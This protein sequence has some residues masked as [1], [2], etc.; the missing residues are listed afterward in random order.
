MLRTAFSSIRK[1]GHHLPVFWTSV[2]W[3]IRNVSIPLFLYHC[4]QGGYLPDLAIPGTSYASN[5]HKQEMLNSV[6]LFSSMSTYLVP[7]RKSTAQCT[8]MQ[9]VVLVENSPMS[10]SS[11]PTDYVPTTLASHRESFIFACFV[12]SPFEPDQHYSRTDETGCLSFMTMVRHR[13]RLA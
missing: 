7:S 8:A 9:V 12:R 2:L 1:I 5:P 11:F 4:S 3:S 6:R 13:G 10:P